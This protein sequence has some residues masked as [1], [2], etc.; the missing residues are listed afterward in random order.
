MAR[1]KYETGDVQARERLADAFW[2]LLEGEPYTQMSA[3][4][5]CRKAGLNKNTFYYHF[6]DLDEL[7]DEAV[8]RALPVELALGI[9]P[10]SV[11]S[12]SVLRR[13]PGHLFQ[14]RLL[15]RPLPLL[16]SATQVLSWSRP[17]PA[18]GWP[19]APARSS[20]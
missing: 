20:E 12:H 14:L 18:R 11:W 1:P 19:A 9:A 4:E 7:A 17:W 5:V 13:Q 6:S 15:L 16:G 2:N 8:A 3:R 10:A